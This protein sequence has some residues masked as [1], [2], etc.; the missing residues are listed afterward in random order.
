MEGY[1]GP[2]DYN[3]LS[4]GIGRDL[5]AF[6][7]LS[8][9]VTESRARLPDEGK[10]LTG[11]SYRLSYSKRFEEYDSQVTFAGYRF[12]ERDFMSMS[13]Y[14]DR[15]Y[16]DG[17]AESS[18]ELYTIML[19]KQFTDLGIS[20]Y[21]NY[22]HQ[23]YWNQSNNDRYN[24]SVSRYFA[25]GTI[26][27]INLN[28][29]AYRNKYEGKN[30]D[31]MYL[32]LS[33]PWGNS[34]TI[35]Y[36]AMVNRKGNSNT[37]GYYDRINENSSYRLAAGTS[38]DGK[39]AA[40]GYLTHYGD[41][42]QLTTSASYQ[43]GRYTSAA[44][45]VQGGM[46][47][48]PEGAAL[49]RINTPG[50]TRL[51]VDTDGVGDVPVKGFGAITHTNMFGKAVISDV[52]NYYRN[53]A[54]IDLNKLPDNV[55][56]IRSVQQATLTEGAIGY[57]KFQVISGEK[58]MSMI[59]LSD[60]STPPFGA[61]VLNKDKRE[62]GI[63]NDGGNTYLSGINPGEKLDVRW[64]GELQCVIELPHELPIVEEMASLLLP[65]QLVNG[66]KQP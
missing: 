29:S 65:C 26:K 14:L 51:M 44:L 45:A 46:T 3:A 52:N 18:K 63:V 35:S 25:I 22:S 42:A 17:D 10:T 19:N 48:T 24:I 20:T 34:G 4:L 32:T 31:S 11:G 56:A 9:D 60:G 54:S 33:L 61:T 36:N 13:Q 43:D 57:R 38:I 6:G 2:G 59:R 41:L 58:A 23:T 28:L 16:H 12:S 50:T 49:H 37:V 66:N 1:W 8:F 55:E 15:R 53:S 21:L 5:M 30:D 47:I 27:N 64:D 7:A 40:N 39:A 62:I